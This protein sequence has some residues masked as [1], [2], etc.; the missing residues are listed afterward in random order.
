MRNKEREGEEEGPV[1][2]GSLNHMTHHS[3]P[4]QM[5]TSTLQPFTQPPQQPPTSSSL[6]PSSARPSDKQQCMRE[7]S[8]STQSVEA[9]VCDEE[10]PVVRQPEQHVAMQPEQQPSE[11]PARPAWTEQV[12]ALVK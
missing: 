2:M 4:Q 7:R 12:A 5:V 3:L 1:D 10:E 11:Q 8:A 9:M 6:Y